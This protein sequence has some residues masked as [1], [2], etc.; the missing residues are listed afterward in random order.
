MRFYDFLANSD[1]PAGQATLITWD[2]RATKSELNEAIRLAIEWLQPLAEMRVGFQFCPSVGGFATLAALDYL[3]C[4]T[5]L[6]DEQFSPSST[7]KVADEFELCAMV[8]GSRTSNPVEGTLIRYDSAKQPPNPGVTI[9]TSGTEGIPKAARH[10]WESL[11]RPVR[12]RKNVGGLSWLLAFRP[13]LY[14]GLQVILQCL[15]NQ[16]CLVIPRFG[17][18]VVDV[19]FDDH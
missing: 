6:L 8:D 3:G 18:E 17:S 12:I 11:V 4:D 1:G 16:G 7:A 14:A 5:F 15:A 13:H 10:T 9:L 19:A 2:D